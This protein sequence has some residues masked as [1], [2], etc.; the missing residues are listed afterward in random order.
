MSN[1]QITE[2]S[3]LVEKMAR[4]LQSVIWILQNTQEDL[5]HLGQEIALL[6]ATKQKAKENKVPVEKKAKKEKEK[7]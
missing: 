2:I 1:E 3:I 7:K 6:A 5:R 4:N